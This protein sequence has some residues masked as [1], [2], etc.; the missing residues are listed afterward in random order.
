MHDSQDMIGD[1]WREAWFPN[2]DH[3]LY[4]FNRKYNPYKYYRYGVDKFLWQLERFGLAKALKSF[5]MHVWYGYRYEPTRFSCGRCKI[6]GT[7][8]HLNSRPCNPH[9]ERLS[10]GYYPEP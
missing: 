9:W 8:K 7:L 10:S 6:E 2:Y 5:F 4:Q 3:E 1:E